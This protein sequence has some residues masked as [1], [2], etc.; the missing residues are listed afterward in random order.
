MNCSGQDLKIIDEA[1]VCFR[2]T[3]NGSAGCHGLDGKRVCLSGAKPGHKS[4]EPDFWLAAAILY[5]IQFIMGEEGQKFEKT[6]VS[7]GEIRSKMGTAFCGSDH[8]RSYY[9]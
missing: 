6:Y 1:D 7:Q 9:S 4:V 3:V 2:V 8:D 5:E